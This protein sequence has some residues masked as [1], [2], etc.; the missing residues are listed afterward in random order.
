MKLNVSI[1]LHILFKKNSKRFERAYRN[2][3]KCLQNFEP[4]KKKLNKTNNHNMYYFVN[5]NECAYE[6]TTVNTI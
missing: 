4:K 6:S 3:K 1:N 5:E 2:N